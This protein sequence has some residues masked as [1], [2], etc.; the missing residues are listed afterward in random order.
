M[1]KPEK[2]GLSF[3]VIGHPG[4]G[5]TPI[6][7]ELIAF[8]YHMQKII[9]DKRGEYN[10]KKDVIFYKLHNLLKIIADIFGKIIIVEEAT[11]VI[12]S[13]S[14][15][16]IQEM[17]INVKHNNNI[18]FYTFHSIQDCPSYL[19]NKVDYVVLLKTGEDPAKI[20]RNYPKFHSYESAKL[21]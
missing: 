16:D 17:L 18:V 13:Y 8:A 6:I 4:S 5:K 7:Q 21:D 14:D 15:E 20:K 12:R 3:V 2:N 1:K 10:A 11:G 19:I 9:Y